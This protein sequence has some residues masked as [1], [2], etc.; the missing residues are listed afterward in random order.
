VR[1]RRYARPPVAARLLARRVASPDVVG[2]AQHLDVLQGGRR[3]DL[4]VDGE[5]VLR[6][7]RQVA[8][9]LT[10]ERLGPCARV[11]TTA[12]S[13][14]RSPSPSCPASPRRPSPA[15]LPRPRRTGCPRSARRRSGRASPSPELGSR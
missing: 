1:N 9:R 13:D 8:P 3:P 2:Q 10:A 15:A 4:V 7:D 5:R 14:A 6:R 12:A 11:G